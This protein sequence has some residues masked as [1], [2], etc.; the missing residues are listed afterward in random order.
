MATPRVKQPPPA[1]AIAKSLTG[2][3]TTRGLKLAK[4]SRER[5]SEER[6]AQLRQAASQLVSSVIDECRQRGLID[7]FKNKRSPGLI[8]SGVLDAVIDVVVSRS[9]FA[10]DPLTFVDRETF[11][12]EGVDDA[13]KRRALETQGSKADLFLRR[14]FRL[15]RQR[16]LESTTT[17]VTENSDGTLTLRSVF[18]FQHFVSKACVEVPAEVERQAIL[19]RDYRDAV[20]GQ[21]RDPRWQSVREAHLRLNP[22]CAACGGTE[23][24]SV[25]HIRPFALN[26]SLEIEPSNLIT[27]CDYG[28]HFT[29]GHLG[30][31]KRENPSVVEDA[32]AALRE[33]MRTTAREALP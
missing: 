22:T 2:F 24:L 3:L 19:D 9:V 31:W 12:S 29:I 26:P 4:A 10:F 5:L 17:L 21:S 23:K 14:Y 16:V 6:A 7:S 33:A 15:I 28:C 18:Q 30:D 20:V 27:L 32:A 13:V 25:H 11:L 1:H 8:D